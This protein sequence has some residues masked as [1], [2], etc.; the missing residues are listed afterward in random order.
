MNVK[1]WLLA[2]AA[3]G[4]LGAAAFYSPYIGINAGF[5]PACLLCPHVTTLW[6]TPTERF[7]RFTIA[8]GVLNTTFFAAVGIVII[9]L[10]RASKYAFRSSTDV[11]SKG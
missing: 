2:S 5:Q 4:F 10:I 9:G 3:M 11:L 1:K 8:G 6:G 7:I